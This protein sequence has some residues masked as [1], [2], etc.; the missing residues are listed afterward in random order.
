MRSSFKAVF[1]SCIAVLAFGCAEKGPIL[2]SVAYQPPQGQTPP[3]PAV[4][5]VSPFVDSRG[6]APSALGERTIPDG[7]I[8]DLVVQGT[9]SDIVTTA[10][11]KALAARGITVQDAAWDL[12]EQSIPSVSA[13]LLIGGDITAL[14]LDTTAAGFTT[15]LHATIRMKIVVGDAAEKKIIRTI[16]V[17]SGIEQEMLYSREKLGQALSEALTTAI[18]Q[19]FTDEELGKRL[20]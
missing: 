2:L 8:N 15:K 13:P 14:R 18:N 1:I 7:Q 19:I 4:I 16:N 10:L 20:R 6:M 17:S 3:S 5:A 11:K 9:V 12:Q